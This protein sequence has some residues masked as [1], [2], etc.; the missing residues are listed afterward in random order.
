MRQLLSVRSTPDRHRTRRHMSSHR[1]TE[2]TAFRSE[3]NAGAVTDPASG[4][5]DHRGRCFAG[6]FERSIRRRL[7]SMSPLRTSILAVVAASSLEM[8]AWTT[9]SR[10]IFRTSPLNSVRRPA[11]GGMSEEYHRRGD[12]DVSNCT[13]RHGQGRDRIRRGTDRFVSGGRA[14]AE[15]GSDPEHNQRH[16]LRINALYGSCTRVCRR[17][18]HGDLPRRTRRTPA[19][20]RSRPE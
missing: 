13:L 8:W 9:I 14:A 12:A 4:Q 6:P 3:E 17:A 10:S 5:S 2:R 19:R 11:S 16:T 20:R 15:N 7:V 1:Y 18:G